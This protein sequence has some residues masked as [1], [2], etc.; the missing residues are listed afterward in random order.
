MNYV[1]PEQF[2]GR[3]SNIMSNVAADRITSCEI[4]RL[5]RA[6]DKIDEP[7]VAFAHAAVGIIACEAHRHVHG[8]APVPELADLTEHT[9]ALPEPVTVA[10]RALIANYL[11]KWFRHAVTGETQMVNQV[12]VELKHM[13]PDQRAGCMTVLAEYARQQLRELTCSARSALLLTLSYAPTFDNPQAHLVL[14][15][16]AGTIADG[17]PLIGSKAGRSLMGCNPE[18]VAAMIWIG[19]RTAACFVAPGHRAPAMTI[20]GCVCGGGERAGEILTQWTSDVA[21]GK[22]DSRAYIARTFEHIWVRTAH[23]AEHLLSGAAHLLV[24][25]LTRES[26]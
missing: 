8:H 13:T 22:Q 3:W 9:R 26:S 25:H 19:V 11:L 21:A 18:A 2:V 6:H 16:C 14:A 17:L 20:P 5:V 4:F 12:V 15:L 23:L 24:P 7:A 1:V 10:D